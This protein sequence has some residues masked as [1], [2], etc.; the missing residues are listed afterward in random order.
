MR[1]RITQPIPRLALTSVVAFLAAGLVILLPVPAAGQ[2][3]SS[4]RT[5]TQVMDDYYDDKTG[6][7]YTA[8]VTV[9]QTTDLVY[10]KVKVSW[11]GLRPTDSTG[12][13]PVVIMQCWGTKEQA[14]QQTCWNA[15][16]NVGTQ[17]LGFGLHDVAFNPLD[18]AARQIFGPSPVE[19]SVVPFKARDDGKLYNGWKGETG[20]APGQVVKENPTG[21]SVGTSNAVMPGAYLGTTGTNGTGEHDIELLTDFELK[22]LGCNSTT[23]CSLVVIPI[24]DPHCNATRDTQCKASSSPTLRDSKTW[25]WPTNWS[26]RLKFDLSF[27]E[28]PAACELDNRQETSFA[29]ST[30]AYQV[31]NNSWRPKFCHDKDLFKL[32]YTGLSDGDARIQ[33]GGALSGTWQDGSTNALLTSRP[34]EG[35]APKPFVYAPVT[36]T[37]VAVSFVLDGADRKEVTGLKL[38]ARLLAKMITQ[39]YR[40]QAAAGVDH[41]TLKKNPTWWG[42]DEEFIALNR[43]LANIGALSREGS[44]YPV[45]SIGDLDALY[46]L[47]AYIAADKDAMDWINGANDGHGMFV[48]PMFHQYKLPVGKLELRDDWKVAN[49]HVF[50]GHILL[51]QYSNGAESLYNAAIAATQG[52][53]TANIGQSCVPDPDP[54]KPQTCTLKRKEARQPGGAR[55][56]LAITTLGDA[57]VFG[58]RQAALQT[59]PTTFVQ[60]DDY[61]V[62]LALRG[63]KLDEKTGVL[64]T[65]FTKMHSSMYPG[66]SIVYAAVPT[67]GLS[68]TTADNYAKFLEYA[69]GPGQVQG[70]ASGQLP[71]GYVPLSDPLREQA[72]NAARAVREQKGEVPAPPPG[73][74]NDPAGGL[75]PPVES[76]GTNNVAGNGVTGNGNQPPGA[77]TPSPST[78]PT[79]PS[80][81]DKAATSVATRT[82]SSGFAKWVLPGLLAISVLAGLIAFGAMVW[83]QPQHPVRRALRTV[84]GRL[85][86][87]SS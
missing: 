42:A 67:I 52:W 25:M 44:E 56:M 11:S 70:F 3:A 79:E 86:R 13:Y 76:N 30:Y 7:A 64:A 27:R 54:T 2:T 85:S 66:M 38:N 74:A 40:T 6:T 39:S 4:A 73:L 62:A 26:R 65:D 12:K 45:I 71:G 41:P 23:P 35:D 77:T 22:H 24:G 37:S 81:V 83:T 33:F 17:R 82:D 50:Q 1:T 32:G 72:R 51:Q 61:P 8:S 75:L 58:L 34:L 28:S 57:K 36:V 63:T 9:S 69:A 43:D 48:N 21:F 5:E 60:P 87:R 14:T 18:P 29:G 49:S 47:T 46:A 84:V 80:T 19:A 53:P 20:W 15:G 78:S 55:A 31:L 68:G 10:Q 16:T 59:S